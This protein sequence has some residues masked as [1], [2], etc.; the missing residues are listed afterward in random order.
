M[1]R[2][3]LKAS[4]QAHPAAPQ[5]QSGAD[6]GAR[7]CEEQAPAEDLSAARSQLTE[8][9]VGN[10]VTQIIY[11]AARLGIPDLLDAAPLGAAELAQ[12][13]GTNFRA[14]DAMLRA[15]VSMDVFARDDEGRFTL[16]PMGRLLRSYPGWR[17]QALLL[18]E[19]YFRSS[20]ELMHTM[21]TG[22][23]A[24][25]RAHGKSF[26]D[27][28]TK[29]PVA[30]ARFHEVMTLSAPV[31]YAEI[32]RAFDFSRIARLVDVGAGRGGLTS[33]IMKTYP[34]LK[35]VVFDAPQII[36][37]AGNFL[38]DEGVLDRCELVGGDF[39]AS[40][41]RGGDAYLLSSV[42]V[43][44]DDDHALTLLRNCRDA[45]RTEASLII[46]DHAFLDGTP[47]SAAAAVTA[48]AAY[49]IQGSITRT[50]AEYRALLDRAGFRIE[51][52]KPLS[53]EPYVM[54]HARP[55]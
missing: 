25:D 28:F 31:R 30:A 35:A 5:T 1:H 39:F 53:Y 24:F 3:L 22:E 10:F 16:R 23:P 51:E 44:W 19:E 52:I 33:L 48:I 26:Y 29:D 32:P 12:R 7:I 20:A 34:Q 14:L 21:M 27:Y 47:P 40:I 46:V 36:A 2:L 9:M 15:M 37:A 43:N 54:L 11:L 55:L 38:R 49:A 8:L 50:E 18:G 17:S 13:T 4:W 42:I 45:M 41:P 6:R